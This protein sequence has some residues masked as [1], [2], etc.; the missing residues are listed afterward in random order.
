MKAQIC[1]TCVHK[2]D[3]CYCSPNST[4]DKY[5]KIQMVEKKSWEEF[6]NN[7][8]L[9]WI[10]MILHT[11]GWAICVDIEEDGSVSNAY[12]ARVKFRGFAEKNNT[13][14]YIKVSQY[15]KDNVDELV[16]EAND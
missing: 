16:K 15:L 2:H 3:R 14:G 13:D 11:F 8:F 1:E 9:W 5:K 7:G 6:K 12:P 10:N 4:C